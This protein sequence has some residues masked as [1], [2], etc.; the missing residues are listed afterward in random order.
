MGHSPNLSA[1]PMIETFKLADLL[2]RDFFKEP[3]YRGLDWKFDPAR[4]LTQGTIRPEAQS[5]AMEL[6]P[7]IM[8]TNDKKTPSAN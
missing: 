3:P 1:Q 7:P 4:N 5:F 8:P 2:F 6:A